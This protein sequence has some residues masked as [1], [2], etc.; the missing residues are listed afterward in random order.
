MAYQA[1]SRVFWRCFNKKHANICKN[2]TCRSLIGKPYVNGAPSCSYISTTTDF[3]EFQDLTHIKTHQDLYQLSIEKP[4]IFWSRLARSRLTWSKDFTT[5]CKA[6][7]SSGKVEWFDGGMLNASVN[8]L[9]RHLDTKADDIALIWERDEPG[10]HRF[11]TYRKLS[12]MVGKIG[13]LLLNSGVKAGDRVAIY[14]PKSPTAIATMLA[15]AR[16]GAIHSVVFAGFSAEALAG[17]INDARAETVVTANQTIRG[18]KLIELKK[19]VDAAVSKCPGV[20]RV[21]IYFRTEAKVPMGKLDIDMTEA[22]Q[23]ESPDCPVVQR[24]SEDSLFM[25]YTSG[26][27][28][29]PKGITHSTSGY[30]LY[31]NLT[32]KQTFDYMAGERFGCVADIGWITGHSYVLYGPLSNGGTT[33]LF[34]S[35]PL[36]PNPGRYWEMV[37]RLKLNHL[38]L[39]PTSLRMLLK[40]GNDYVWKYDRSSLRK[41]GCVGEPLNHE[42]WEWYYNVVGEKRCDIID[43]WW[44]TETGGICI[45]PRPSE[46]G[47]EIKP[48]MPMRPMFGID[49]AIYDSQGQE[50][51]GNNVEGALCIRKP[52]PGMARTIYGDHDRFKKTYFGVIPGVYYTGD[53]AHRHDNGYYQIT[54]RMDDVLNVSG[55]RL[56]TAEIEDVM[57]D[58]PDVAE[59]AVVGFPHDIKG[60]G[61]YAYAV[62]KDGRTKTKKEIERELR[63]AIKTKIGGLA[64]PEVILFTPNLPRT[65]SG[66][67]MRRI[68]RKVAA[69]KFDELGD[70]S[71]LSEPEVVEFIVKKHKELSK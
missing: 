48:G 12:E 30:L 50:V 13:N 23:H 18:G 54:G 28:G 2:K 16:I 40:A 45:S 51:N 55:H 33:L 42:A 20:K 66:K 47:A 8:C 32:F 19:T 17:R 15:C 58:H 67:I 10:T 21:F 22:L 46:V 44:Q 24:Q 31:A 43:T 4:E 71:T 3:P 49:L 56:G 60:E 69:N 41:L 53:G 61:I 7:F 59:T 9:D 11:Y 1:L 39:A 29:A 6:D 63:E 57:D 35:T 36:Y 34:E 38:Y 62:L 25:L 65:R 64:M 5:T 26:S 52:W 68:L 27:T 37:E 14:L 70:I